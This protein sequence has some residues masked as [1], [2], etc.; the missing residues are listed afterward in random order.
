MAEEIDLTLAK[1]TIAFRIANEKVMCDIGLHAGQV[2]VLGSLWNRDGQSQ[3]GIVRDLCISAPTVNKMVLKLEKSGLVNI[4]KCPHDK[5]LKRVYL[6]PQGRKV[7]PKV[8]RQRRHLNKVLLQDLS[9]T[10]ILLL[11]ILLE[12]ISKNLKEDFDGSV[13]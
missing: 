13:E 5:R 10:E 9:E 11:P 3:A 12:K 4:R 1:L 6:T 2:Q 8:A 7:K